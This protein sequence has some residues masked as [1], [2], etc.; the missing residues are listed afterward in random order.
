MMRAFF[1][2]ISKSQW[3]Q[4]IFTNWSYAWKIASRFVAGTEIKDAMRVVKQLN[5]EGFVVTLDHLGEQTEDQQAATL[6]T[7]EILTLMEAIDQNQ[8][9]SNVS[10]KLTQIGLSLDP[11]ICKMNLE[12]IIEKAVQTHLFIR[13]D[14]EDSSLTD[15]TLEILDWARNLYAGIGIVIQSY[16]F[17]SEN[18]V[19]T[20]VEKTIPMRIVKGAYK[21][22]YSIAF[23]KKSDVDQNFDHLVEVIFNSPSSREYTPQ[24]A[25]IFPAFIG[26]ATHDEKRIVNGLDIVQKAGGDK[27]QVEIQMLYGI[28]KDLQEKYVKTAYSVR[29]YVPYGSHWFPYFMRRLAERPA[30]VW[31]FVSNFLHG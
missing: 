15:I 9:I 29:V 7:Q 1:I 19:K 17:R 8:V 4:K 23:R 10:I 12:K 13:I 25:G 11:E 27:E 30:N 21:E 6:A 3:L 14:M 26:L 22:P 16:L 28:R 31:F 20:L 5:Q 2:S 18:D 24:V